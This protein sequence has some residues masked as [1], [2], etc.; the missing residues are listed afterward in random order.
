MRKTPVYYYALVIAVYILFL[1]IMSGCKMPHDIGHKAMLTAQGKS[2]PFD[3][4]KRCP[5]PYVY[6]NGEI[7]RKKSFYEKEKRKRIFI[8][9][10]ITKY[11]Y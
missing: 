11:N 10:N 7:M 5:K 4:I 9:G 1:F 6:Y 8:K 2:L 3:S